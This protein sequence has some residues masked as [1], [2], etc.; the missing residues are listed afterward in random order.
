MRL[1]KYLAHA[2]AGTRKEVKQWIRKGF[3]QVNE[4]ICKK[5][6]IH[7]QEGIDHIF[8]HE[9]EIFY[10]EFYYIMLHKPVDVV[11]AVSDAVYETV[12]DLI[13]LPVQGLFPVGRLDMDTEG[14][15]LITND[16]VLSHA[17]LSPKKHVT[18]LYEVQIA[19]PLSHQEITTLENGTIVLDDE[20]L[21]PAK[22]AVIEPCLIHLSI[23]QG[24]F[25]QVKRMLQAVHNEVVALKRL[26]MGSLCLDETLQPGD[27]RFLSEEELSALKEGRQ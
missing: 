27:W 14:L 24:K 8:L 9:E 17:L 22:V 13:A 11:S 7:I 15:L 21:Q 20:V 5:D 19:H 16:G 10:Q 23:T 18:K 25:H 4:E 1:D 3:V 26:Q 2:G 6:D 12:L